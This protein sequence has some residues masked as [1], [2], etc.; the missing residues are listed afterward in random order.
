MVV[1]DTYI[2]NCMTQTE[3]T[4]TVMWVE[5]TPLGLCLPYAQ[6]T[7]IGVERDSVSGVKYCL[8]KLPSSG[9][10]RTTHAS[11]NNRFLYLFHRVV[12]QASLY[13][14][15]ISTAW[16]GEYIVSVIG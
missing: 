15:A 2:L 10:Y 6:A 5:N 11:S 12:L 9:T 16:L 1:A 7:T 3:G 14:L 4:P 8:V 13:S